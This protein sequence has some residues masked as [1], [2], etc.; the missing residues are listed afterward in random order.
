MKEI[1]T[2]Q[3]IKAL[4]KGL[5]FLVGQLRKV[6]KGESIL[7]RIISD[8]SSAGDVTQEQ[9]EWGDWLNKELEIR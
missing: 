7:G 5:G 3:L 1:S 8:D 4:I 2:E 6:L 9:K